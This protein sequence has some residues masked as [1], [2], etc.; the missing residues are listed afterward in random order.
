MNNFTI[1]IV[2]ALSATAYGFRC[3][4]LTVPVSL[5][6]RN[7]VFN[8]T[9]PQNNVEVTNLILDLTRQG[10]SF[11]EQRVQG[12]A[13]VHGNYS[14]AAT[15][16]TPEE[17]GPNEPESSNRKRPLAVQILTHGL[18]FDRSYWDLP[19]NGGNYSY[20][21][22]ATNKHGYATLSWDRLGVGMSSHGEP[23][24][25]IQAWLEVDALR[26]LTEGLRHGSIEGVP[27]FDRVLHVGHSF[28]STHVYALTAMYPDISDGIALTGFSQNGSFVPYFALGANF[29]D[30][31]TIPL[32]APQYDHGY[33]A[34]GDL[35]AFQAN[36]LGPE[37]FDPAI[38]AFAATIG[39]P[40]AI[41]EILTIGSEIASLNTF[42]GPVLVVTGEY[43]VPFCG[44]SCYNGASPNSSIPAQSQQYWTNT[45]IST[46]I[47]PGAGHAL[48]LE[49]SH[50][51]TYKS[52][53]EFFGQIDKA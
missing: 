29:V 1:A 50:P 28:G 36:F 5:S 25:E 16:C 3:T 45:S 51:S 32:L 30:V 24:N 31:K 6:A 13:A 48:N 19:Y 17:R 49:Y 38:L 43:D 23:I 47:V 33:L 2:A 8:I 4:N 46:I 15:Y 39:Q 18:G 34:T 11:V 9:T 21:A 12:Y 26:A 27:S 14:L 40:L 7:V 44:G 35:S 22:I 37:Q 41:G 52:I 20:S 42:R 53:N 10:G